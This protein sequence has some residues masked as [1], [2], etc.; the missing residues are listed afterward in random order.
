MGVV[1]RVFIPETG[2]KTKLIYDDTQQIREW[3]NKHSSKDNTVKLYSTK[4]IKNEIIFLK[5]ALHV[6]GE[7]KNVIIN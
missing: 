5:E 2:I 3:T 7:W 6:F 1:I 4:C